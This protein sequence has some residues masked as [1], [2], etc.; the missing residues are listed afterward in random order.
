M[1]TLLGTFEASLLTPSQCWVNRKY[2]ASRLWLHY[3]WIFVCMFGTII[4]Y[5]LM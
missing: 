5:A 3:F 2:E 4:I 1:G